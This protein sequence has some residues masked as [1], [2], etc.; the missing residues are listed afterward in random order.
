M[1]IDRSLDRSFV[2]NDR[3]STRNGLIV[4][5]FAG[6]IIL[7]ALC[8]PYGD[9]GVKIAG[10]SAAGLLGTGGGIGIANS[11]AFPRSDEEL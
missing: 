4:A 7:V 11:T 8:L 2:R 1:E 6:L 10:I 3:I 5:M 9:S